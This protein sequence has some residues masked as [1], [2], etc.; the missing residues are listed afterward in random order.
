MDAELFSHKSQQQ[1]IIE[2]KKIKISW[3]DKTKWND[4]LTFIFREAWLSMSYF[5]ICPRHNNFY[6]KCFLHNLSGQ[7]IIFH[8][9]DQFF[10]NKIQ[11]KTCF[12][13]KI[14]HDNFTVHLDCVS[15]LLQRRKRIAR[16]SGC[17]RTKIIIFLQVVYHIKL[18][19]YIIIPTCITLLLHVSTQG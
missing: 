12:F 5:L 2:V 7:I 4:H 6:K 15:Y 17:K 18:I 19:D 11:R 14:K 9:S 13:F 10:S 3:I 16:T 8:L 1:N